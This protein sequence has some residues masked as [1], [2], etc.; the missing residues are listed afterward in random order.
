MT[1]SLRPWEIHSFSKVKFSICVLIATCKKSKYL[2]LY[3]FFL[4]IFYFAFGQ[5]IS[6]PPL[7]I[8]LLKQ[9]HEMLGEIVVRDRP[10][11]CVCTKT[12]WFANVHKI[13]HACSG[14]VHFTC[15]DI[16]RSY[17]CW[18]WYGDIGDVIYLVNDLRL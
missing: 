2:S 1:T 18:W 7:R 5:R 16:Y 11:R 10:D 14:S 12:V 8:C 17:L 9:N 13:L 4:Y 15:T 6:T 3:L